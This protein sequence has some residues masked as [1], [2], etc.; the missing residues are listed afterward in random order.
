MGNHGWGGISAPI[1]CDWGGACL[2]SCSKHLGLVERKCTL[3]ESRAI[4]VRDAN[5]NAGLF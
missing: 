1:A 5:D 4:E 3:T 2:L